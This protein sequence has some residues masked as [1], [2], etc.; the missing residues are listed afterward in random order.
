MEYSDCWCDGVVVGDKKKENI[1]VVDKN[2][3]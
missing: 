2:N 3:K 1:V